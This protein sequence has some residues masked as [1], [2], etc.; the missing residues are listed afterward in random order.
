MVIRCAHPWVDTSKYPVVVLTFPETSSA[1]EVRALTFAL[2]QFA[3]EITEP[4]ALISDLSKIRGSDPDVRQVYVDFVKD[5]RAGAST[6]LR[7]TA[8]VTG[9]PFQRTVLNL[10]ALLVGKTPYPVRAFPNATEALPWL[11]AKIGP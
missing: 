11:L 4:F 5:M 2:R 3:A 10:H 7:A 1:A 8:V 9:N 6:W